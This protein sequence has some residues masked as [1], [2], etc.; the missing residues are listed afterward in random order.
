VFGPACN[1][2]RAEKLGAKLRK[3]FFSFAGRLGRLGFLLRGMALGITT[4]VLLVVGFTLFLH[5][6]LWWLGILI[7]VIALVALVVGYTLLVVR[8]L[9]DVNFSGYH[10]IW[11]VPIG[12]FGTLLPAVLTS[13]GVDTSR[14]DDAIYTVVAVVGATLLLWPGSKGENR[15][16]ATGQ[17]EKGG[18]FPEASRS[19]AGTEIERIRPRSAP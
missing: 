14:F 2:F 6:A 12:L 18:G 7:T 15:A 17:I 5:G 9:H 4:G 16:L 11:V 8:R 3:L 13:E 1:F 10:A 19:E